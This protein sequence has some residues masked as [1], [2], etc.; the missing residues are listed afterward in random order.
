VL[1]GYLIVPPS[2]TIPEDFHLDLYNRTERTCAAAGHNP[3]KEPNVQR[4]LWRSADMDR[5]VSTPEMNKALEAIL[6]PSYVV[7]P[8]RHMHTCSNLAGQEWHQDPSIFP[9][10]SPR[11]RSVLAMYY[12]GDCE[13][14]DGPTGFLPGSPYMALVARLRIE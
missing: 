7:Y 13:L 11:C 12:P 6:G 14:K 5:V 2:A 10:R 9:I 3:P 4:E 8:H 1:N